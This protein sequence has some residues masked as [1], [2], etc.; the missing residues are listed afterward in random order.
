MSLDPAILGRAL[1]AYLKRAGASMS[2]HDRATAKTHS[3]PYAAARDP[4]G[5]LPV[6][7]VAG[8]AVWQEAAG[9]GFALDIRADP[10]ALFGRR[11]HAVGAGTFSTVM[12]SVIEA[13]TQA[14][15]PR[16][17]LVNDLGV[18]WADRLARLRPAPSASAGA[19]P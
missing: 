17:L 1:E 19:S 15:G 10:D 16:A 7:V 8:E 13:T 2:F 12:L 6:F 14:A 3:L 11:L 18:Q 4:S 5:L 9:K